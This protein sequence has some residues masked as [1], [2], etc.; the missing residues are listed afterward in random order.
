MQLYLPI[1]YKGR[2]L[3]PGACL[4]YYIGAYVTVAGM[5]TSYSRPDT[6]HGPMKILELEDSTATYTVM[7]WPR[8]YKLIGS[9]LY[10]RGPFLVKGR[11]TK[12][13]ETSPP[14]VEAG[15]IERIK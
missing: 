2:R 8:V 14:I 12:E 13:F 6:K 9:I 4:R 1:D 11:V 5:V 10:D 7:V 3:I 15:W